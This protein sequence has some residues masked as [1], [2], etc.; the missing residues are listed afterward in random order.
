[1]PA[2][3]I[4]RGASLW[5]ICQPFDPLKNRV[6]VACR[7]AERRFLRDIPV[8]PIELRLRLW[9]EDDTPG[10]SCAAASIRSRVLAS[11]SR[12]SS[13]ERPRVGSAC[14]AS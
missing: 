13:S 11:V 9:R 12:T 3:I 7:N 6:D 8:K 4:P 14:N 10:H 2:D 1:M 5:E